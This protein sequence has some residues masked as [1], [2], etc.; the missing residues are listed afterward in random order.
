VSDRRARAKWDALALSWLDTGPPSIPSSGDLLLIR[1]AL[2]GLRPS[3]SVLLGCTPSIR[4]LLGAEFAV[5][6]I[7]LVDF[8]RPMVDR[9]TNQLRPQWPERVFESDWLEDVGLRD[10]DVVVGDRALD[11]VPLVLRSDFYEIVRRYLRPGGLFICHTAV[12]SPH[13]ERLS[14]GEL[15]TL[16]LARRTAGESYIVDGLFDDLLTN[17]RPSGEAGALSVAYVLDDIYDFERLRGESD[18][19]RRLV[20]DVLRAYGPSLS[21]EWYTQT[22]EEVLD[23]SSSYFSI[24]DV[25][26]SKDYRAADHHPIIVYSVR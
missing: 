9:T 24:E 17:S 5:P 10:Q 25:Q 6:E 20:D 13:I 14:V 3:S 2:E 4:E 23:E 22:L 11:N 7:S 8:S 15:I 1:A 19:A 21:Q 26:Y 12:A 18:P 16:W